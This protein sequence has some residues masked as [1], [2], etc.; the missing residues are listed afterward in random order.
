MPIIFYGLKIILNRSKPP[1]HIWL[2]ICCILTLLFGASLA[3]AKDKDVSAKEAM[4][5]ALMASLKKGPDNADLGNY[6]N[7][8]LSETAKAYG[9]QAGFSFQYAKLLGEVEQHRAKFGQIFDFRRLLLDNRVLPPVI[10]ASGQATL[11]ESPVLAREVEA[12]YKIVADA[13]IISRPPSFEDY[14]WAETQVLTP[15][16]NIVP[17]T[18]AENKLWE[19]SLAEGFSG[20]I[21][22]AYS[23]FEEAMDR[24]IADYRGI[25]QFK[26]LAKQGLVSLP[27][28]A[29]GEPTVQVGTKV[30]SVN[31]KIFR[32]T[33]PAAFIG[34][35]K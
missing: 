22:H 1:T 15:S 12:Q 23:V 31:E 35:K 5:K 2:S 24:L 27:I 34:G 3:C 32:L 16:Q 30:L 33:M 21:E 11:L 20:G 10:R 6:R 7:Q 17:K 8:I 26:L 28:L 13:R 14:L 25:L 4:N 29:S 19:K 18:K 9:F